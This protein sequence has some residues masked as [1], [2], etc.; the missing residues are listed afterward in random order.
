MTPF[1]WKIFVPRLFPK[2]K[3]WGTARYFLG[4]MTPFVLH[5]L[6]NKSFL[7]CYKLFPEKNKTAQKF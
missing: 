6:C 2:K 4:F 1:F 7:I 5:V 3:Y